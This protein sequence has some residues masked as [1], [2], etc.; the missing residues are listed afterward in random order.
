[1]HASKACMNHLLSLT[2]INSSENT[3][4]NSTP[5]FLGLGST[6]QVF[7]APMLML[8]HFICP[9]R[10]AAKAPFR[11]CNISFPFDYRSVSLKLKMK[12]IPLKRLSADCITYCLIITIN[13]HCVTCYIILKLSCILYLQHLSSFL[14]WIQP[15]FLPYYSTITA[16]FH[17]SEPSILKV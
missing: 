5:I 10:Y 2:Y 14:S 3:L 6:S 4:N 15:A 17:R 9:R 11:F 13:Y 12:Y 16:P 8:A 1:M 7:Y